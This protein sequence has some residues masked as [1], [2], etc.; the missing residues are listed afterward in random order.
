MQKITSQILLSVLLILT[1]MALTAGSNG[2]KQLPWDRKALVEKLQK[3]G[4]VLVIRH[5]RTEVPSRDD[6]YSKASNDCRAQRNLSVSGSAGAQET[7]VV[8]RALEIKVGRVISSPM[9]RS[10]ETARYMFGVDYDV[11]TRL[12]HEDPKGKRNIDVAT[13]E[14]KEVLKQVAPGL[15]K[16]N[17]ALVSHGGTIIAA[18]GLALSEGEIGV[19]QLDNEGNVTIVDQ[20][21]GSNLSFYAR[22]ALK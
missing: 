7:G 10:A 13:K 3:G 20:F 21:L 6:D 18:T 4:Y 19:I 11:D 1:P 9:C 8:L 14:F 12:M 5:E 22:E 15:P 2:D 16:S 17:I